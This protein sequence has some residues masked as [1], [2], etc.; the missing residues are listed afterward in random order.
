MRQVWISLLHYK[1]QQN[2]LECLLSIQQLKKD[3]LEI[4]VVLINNNSR[5]TLNIDRS[6]FKN[7]SI[8][9]LSNNENLGFAGGHNIGVSY[10]LNQN[11]D[12]VLIVNNDTLFDVDVVQELVKTLE[13]DSA[14]G[15][16]VPKI[17]FAPGCEFHKDRYKKSDLGR[18]IWYAGGVMDWKNVIGHHR[19]VDEVDNGQLD[20]IQETDFATGACML[21][22]AEVF[23]K[24]GM[25][26]ERYFLYYEDN[27]FSIRSKKT[28]F[29]IMYVPDAVMWHKNAGSAGGSGSPL[30]DYYITR[31]RLLFGLRYAPV[32][33]KLSLFRESIKI[34]IRGR[35]WQRRGV[36]DFYLGRFGKGSYPVE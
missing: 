2:T 7:V 27:D 9:L 3:N 20:K 12:S 5:E 10:A 29:K 35:A 36:F 15:I 23:K 22:K 4:H 31:N 32:R 28:G 11:A 1:N 6:Q 25:F 17:Y 8:N 26:D 24:I 16:V 18:V 30:Q 14:I 33:S 34:F 13:F 21:V 19:R